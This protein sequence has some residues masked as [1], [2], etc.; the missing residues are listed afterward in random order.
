MKMKKRGEEGMAGW[1]HDLDSATQ[2]KGSRQTADRRDHILA[3][4]PSVATEH[5]KGWHT[6]AAPLGWRCGMALTATALRRRRREALRRR[7]APLADAA[8][9]RWENP[10]SPNQPSRPPASGCLLA[11][12]SLPEAAP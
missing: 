4:M 7:R 9:G 12:S 3:Q 8:R 10:A 2:S 6:S 11:A 5:W 1:D